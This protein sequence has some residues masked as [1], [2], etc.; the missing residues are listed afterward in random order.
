MKKWLWIPI[1]VILFFLYCCQR[2]E[3]ADRRD[4]APEGKGEKKAAIALTIGDN[5]NLA[6]E[7]M[8]KGEVSDGA[9]LLLD[10][11]LLAKP[12]EQWPEGFLESISSAKERFAEGD[13]SGAVARVTMALDLIKDPEDTGRSIESGGVAP[14]AKAMKRKIAEAREEFKKGNV[15]RGVIS[16]LQ[17][18][19]LFAP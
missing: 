2:Q 18:L 7:K 8:E 10:S 13:F 6:E 4:V 3:K 1:L 12:R 11:V 16:V 5:L 17:A 19:Q 15:D 9:V 14:L